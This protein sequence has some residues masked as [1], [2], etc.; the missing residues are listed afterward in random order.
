MMERLFD[1]F[2][3]FDGLL[4]CGPADKS[5]RP[6]PTRDRLDALEKRIELLEKLLKNNS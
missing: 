3:E 4:R 1:K 5:T 6:T 2:R